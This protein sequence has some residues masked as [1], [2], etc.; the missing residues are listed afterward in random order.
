M[1]N[2]SIWNSWIELT[3]NGALPLVAL[4]YLLA[5]WKISETCTTNKCFIESFV[6][7]SIVIMLLL[8]PMLRYA[9]TVLGLK[10]KVEKEQVKKSTLK[11]I[12]KHFSPRIRAFFGV[13]ER[14]GVMNLEKL[15]NDIFKNLSLAFIMLERGE[16]L[17]GH[18]KYRISNVLEGKA[19]NEYRRIPSLSTLFRHFMLNEVV[20]WQEVD[21]VIPIKIRQGFSIFLV[22]P[23]KHAPHLGDLII[24]GYR[25][26]VRNIYD[27]IQNNPDISEEDKQKFREWYSKF[28]PPINPAILVLFP[29][30][31][32]IEVILEYLSEGSSE[33]IKLVFAPKIETIL[34]QTLD[35]G[36]IKLAYLF[37]TVGYADKIVNRLIELDRDI[38]VKI[39]GNPE[40]TLND[41]LALSQPY[42]H[43]M[44]AIKLVDPSLFNE[45][46][47]YEGYLG[48]LR[49]LIRDLEI[50]VHGKTLTPDNTTI[51][52]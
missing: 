32:S 37:E 15:E 3:K 19:P 41:F 25:N 10:I 17:D 35:V 31:T 47:Q 46:V 12:D 13:L 36:R 49:N 29:Y 34:K 43:L 28:N 27:K 1:S 24:G 9:R 38:K 6:I 23:S 48:E 45:V 26:Y 21:N 52:R 40:L 30:Q 51:T 14:R 2:N 44:R 33:D 42:K 18:L 20:T 22:I 4:T 8:Y 39:N 50:T 5:V 16:A 7:V 11:I